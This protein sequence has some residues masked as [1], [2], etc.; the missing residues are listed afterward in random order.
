MIRQSFAFQ[1]ST[2]SSSADCKPLVKESL[3]ACQDMSSGPA[4]AAYF[5]CLCHLGIW[6]LPKNEL[7]NI[8]NVSILLSLLHPDFQVQRHLEPPLMF[9]H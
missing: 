4:F 3:D 1:S 6:D 5:G 2:R 8:P 9:L 7:T